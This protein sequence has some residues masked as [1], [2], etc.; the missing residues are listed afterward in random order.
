MENTAAPPFEYIW[1]G[2]IIVK[3]I[4]GSENMVL[5]I[6]YCGKPAHVKHKSYACLVD[7]VYDVLIVA[8]G[9]NVLIYIWSKV[10]LCIWVSKQFYK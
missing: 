7:K 5:S 8:I 6:I 9:L 10:F 4:I 2:E 1:S 3:S